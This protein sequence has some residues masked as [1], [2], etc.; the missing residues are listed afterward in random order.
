MTTSAPGRS[1]KLHAN[2][3]GLPALLTI[4]QVADLT[5]LSAKTIRRR[6]SDGTF[7]ACRIGPRVIRI[8]RDS[9]L[10]LLTRPTGVA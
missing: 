10:E 8:N 3:T 7:T 9:V 4:D 6:V 2:S 5:G 1:N